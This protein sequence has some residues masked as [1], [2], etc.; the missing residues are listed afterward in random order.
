MKTEIVYATMTGHSK[1]ISS[2]I[3][4]KLGLTAH[5]IKENPQ[6][7]NCDLLYIVSGIYG[8][9]CSPELLKFAQS[10]SSKQVK[11]VAL[12]TS[13]TKVVP[14]KTIRNALALNGIEVLKEEYLCKG[15]F[16]FMAFS[17]P[18]KEEINGA[19]GFAEKL[20]KE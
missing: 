9:D 14:Q 13:S 19:V 10:L 11:K 4:K 8:G 15:A 17:H 12:I 2:A 18:N 3:A 5:N 1:K 6:V 7:S 20:I 16:L